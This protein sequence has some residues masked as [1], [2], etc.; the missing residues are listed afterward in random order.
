MCFVFAKCAH[1]RVAKANKCDRQDCRVFY[2]TTVRLDITRQIRHHR[3]VTALAL[4]SCLLCSDLASPPQQ[5]LTSE[6]RARKDLESKMIK[7]FDETA[8]SLR[9]DLAR[10]KKLREEVWRIYP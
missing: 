1:H 5:D 9:L 8:F 7:L 3:M 10:E 4:S 6:K 2:S